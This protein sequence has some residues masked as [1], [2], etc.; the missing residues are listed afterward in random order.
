[1]DEF[2][3]LDENAGRRL[4]R[5][6]VLVIGAGGL[7][8]AGVLSTWLSRRDME[9]TSHEGE[10]AHHRDADGAT[11]AAPAEPPPTTVPPDQPTRVLAD[12]EHFP[13]GFVVPAGEIWAIA[14]GAAVTSAANVVVEGTLQMHQ[15]DPSRVIRLS[16]VDVDESQF[17]GGDTHEVLASDVGLWMVNEG[18]L[19]VAGA[20]KT[21][22]TRLAGAAGPGA[23]AIAVE[24]ATGWLVGDE[25]VV[26]ATV[27]RSVDGHPE[28][29][30]RAVVTS[31]D[32]NS[33]GLDPALSF[34]HPV[35][36]GRWAAEVVNLSRSVVIEGAPDHKAHIIHLHQEMH[37]ASNFRGSAV[38]HLEL[39]HLG[40]SQT[41]DEGEVAGVLGRYAI[42]WHH[43]GQTTDGVV[44]EG[45]VAHDCGGHAFVPHSSNGMTFQDCAS[46]A[47]VGDAY[48]W[49]PGDNSNY[50]V[51]DRCLASSV[52]EDAQNPYK[53]SGFFAAASGVDQSCV[54]RGCVATGIQ[55]PDSSGYFW[56]NGSY[57]V[58][59]V[60]DCV[61]HNNE[62]AGIRVWQNATDVHVID[63][64]TAYQCQTGISHGAYANPYR[65]HGVTVHDCEVGLRVTAVSNSDDGSAL[66]FHDVVVTAAETPLL[67][68]NAPVDSQRPVDFRRCQFDHVVV[69][70]SHG[71]SQA[72]WDFTDCGLTPD[73][74]TIEEMA[75]GA[76]LRAQNGG[77]AWQIAGGGDWS[78]IA[79]F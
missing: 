62:V 25:V 31:V 9:A 27:G 72:L 33:I 59:V 3:P 65:Y 35:V 6:K 22:W 70:A 16:F 17:V 37:A 75:G 39:R 15:P 34:D 68:E 40:P 36:D 42:H 66:E 26:T 58:W 50:V 55:G 8:S 48:W 24:D 47:T 64:F 14:E 18:R 78:S 76:V 21:G 38:R 67:L 56:D 51:Y 46:H 5:R 77:E 7:A 69:Q 52:I 2:R 23:A 1:M 79:S 53:T 61:A 12:G 28:Q 29:F 63:R 11:R 32:G 44:V 43:G 71:D 60:E 49:D 30:D 73:S 4:T 19:D 13:D 41:N 20:P 45:V 10:H 74:F 57:G 54:M